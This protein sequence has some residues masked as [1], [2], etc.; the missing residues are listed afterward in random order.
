VGPEKLNL[1]QWGRA[2]FHITDRKNLPTILARDLQ[3]KNEAKRLK[4]KHYSIAHENIQERRS[5]KKVPIGRKGTIHDYVPLF[6][7]ARPPMLYA[8]QYK[9]PQEDVIYLLVAWRALELPDTVITDGNASSADTQFY[10]VAGNLDKIDRKTLSLVWWNET[11]EQKRKKAAEVLVWKSLS[12]GL[13]GGI[14]VLNDNVRKAVEPVVAAR[15]LKLQV[16]V[17]P[18]YYYE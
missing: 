2:L 12:I 10:R 13:I 3:A 18:E 1:V 9:V 7:A 6:F 15:K 11:A 8:V 14:V 4:L 5:S 17:A 16:R